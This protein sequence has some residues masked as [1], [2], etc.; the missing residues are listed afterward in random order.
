MAVMAAML[1]LILLLED[2]V[3]HDLTGHAADLLAVEF[4]LRPPPQADHPV[5]RHGGH[6]PRRYAHLD[7]KHAVVA[8]CQ[9]GP[10][11][12]N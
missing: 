3:A 9:N 11:S 7:R 5:R 12:I 2:R 1:P 10:A 8:S 4:L 6:R